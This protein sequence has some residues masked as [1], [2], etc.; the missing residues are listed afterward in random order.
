VAKREKSNISFGSIEKLSHWPH[1]QSVRVVV[2]G[3]TCGWIAQSVG[4]NWDFTLNENSGKTRYL[5]DDLVVLL[6]KMRELNECY[7]SGT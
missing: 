7:D 3:H 6:E 4:G 2:R 5:E 1:C